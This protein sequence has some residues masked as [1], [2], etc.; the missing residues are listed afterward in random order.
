M[1]NLIRLAI[2]IL[3]VQ[4]REYLPGWIVYL[5]YPVFRCL[6]KVLLASAWAVLEYGAENNEGWLGS[7]INQ[8]A[9]IWTAASL[10]HRAAAAT[11]R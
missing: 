1:L 2:F 5:G 4:Y 7:T 8:T 10:V 3:A 11:V 9:E 6:N